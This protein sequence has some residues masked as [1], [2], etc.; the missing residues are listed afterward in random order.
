[1]AL[2][3]GY[4]VAPRQALAASTKTRADRKAETLQAIKLHQLMP[5]GEAG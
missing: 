1:V 4:N 3:N 2:Y 5:A